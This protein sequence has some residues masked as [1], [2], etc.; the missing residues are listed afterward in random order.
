MRKTPHLPTPAAALSF[1]S[2]TTMMTELGD[3][4]Q[5]SVLAKLRRKSTFTERL[6]DDANGIVDIL[7]G[8]PILP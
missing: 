5:P 8:A 1:L 7:I 3:T 4:S 6:R 2:P